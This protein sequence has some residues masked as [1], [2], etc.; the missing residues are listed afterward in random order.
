MV[1]PSNADELLEIRLERLERLDG[2]RAARHDLEVAALA[3]LVDLL[4]RALDRVLLVVQQMLHEHDQLDLAPLIDAIAGAI[5]RRAEKAELALPIAK[6]VRLEAG[7]LADLADREELLNRFRRMG[8]RILLRSKFARHELGDGLARR[9]ALEQNAVDHLARWACRRRVARASASALAAVTTPSATVS[10]PASASSSDAPLPISMPIARL[11]LKR[12]GARE[13]EIAQSRRVRRTSPHRAPSATPSRVIS[14]KPARDQRRARV[15]AEPNAFDDAGRD[16][17]DVLERTAELDAD[18]VVV[19][20]RRESVALL[21][22]ACVTSARASGCVDAA[23][24]A[25]GCRATTSAAKLGPEMPTT[26]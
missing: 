10:F 18:H 14:C 22:A 1:A 2:E 25:V 9:V 13:H 6:H 4:A 19:A 12:A 21:S 20:C 17:H 23:T 16:G 26:A 7:Q 11:R 24:T 3:M 5:L 8:S 15:V